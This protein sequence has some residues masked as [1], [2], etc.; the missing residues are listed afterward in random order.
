MKKQIMALSALALSVMGGLN[1]AHAQDGTVT[2]NGSIVSDTCVL[3]TDSKD[4]TVDFGQ[5]SAI[6][7]SD[8]YTEKD[9]TIDLTACPAAASK[10]TVLLNAESYNGSDVYHIADY[11]DG[12]KSKQVDGDRSHWY[13]HNVEANH[14]MH[15]DGTVNADSDFTIAAG[16]NKL[17][18]RAVFSS[19]MAGPN[20]KI[21][22]HTGE[23]TYTIS[24]Q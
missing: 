2:F 13:I 22:S 19:E 7:P 10:A 5:V 12:V 8:S 21:G 16:D 4:I 23:V 24:Y 6:E 3:S 11:I 18:L 9:F 20:R 17:W 1:M 14:G 15:I